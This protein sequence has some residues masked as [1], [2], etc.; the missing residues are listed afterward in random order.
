M[1]T[2]GV[3]GTNGKTTT[4]RWIATALGALGGPVASVT[5]VGA[6]LDDAPVEA[7][8]D[9]AGFLGVLDAAFRRGGRHAAIELTSE[10]LSLGFAQAWPCRV[11]VFTNL[12]HDHLDAHRT[13]EHYLASKAQLFLQLPAGGAAVL[14]AGDASAQLLAEVVPVG[15]RRLFY[16][17]DARCGGA[18]TDLLV[19]GIEPSWSGT[20]FELVPGT[21]LGAQPLVMQVRGI[22]DVY[23][24]N[25][26]AAVLGAWAA[27]VSIDAAVERVGR[28]PAP[29][30]R[31]EVIGSAPHVVVDYAHTPDA[32]ARTLATARR[33]CAGQLCVVLGAGG[34]RD[35]SKRAPL[36]SAAGA[37]DRIVLTSDNPRDEEP[38][39]IAA[40]IRAGTAGHSGVEVLLDRSLAIA[41]AVR[42]AGAGDVVVVAG[43]GHET[44]QEVQGRRIPLCD[45]EVVRRALGSDSGLC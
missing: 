6:F 32:L 20:R 14:N 16:A 5:T 36:G 39:A 41:A 33:L 19:R 8:A 29:P 11:G 44:E 37:A 4:T 40:E 9:H 34:N 38:A 42:G 30:G 45:V 27:G 7:R 1:L 13:P 15:V 35:R 31:F 43:R 18:A 3:T 22:G 26:A 23:A 10:A 17:S 21:E 24:E 12:T 25:A 28:A 2:V